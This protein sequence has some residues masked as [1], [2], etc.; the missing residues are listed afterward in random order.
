MINWRVRFKN[1]LFWVQVAASFF[2]P[3]LGYFG[4]T[5]QDFTTWPYLF[6][7]VWNAIQNPYVVMMILISL[8]NAVNDPTTEGVRDSNRAM[9]Y[10]K[11]F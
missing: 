8:W 10:K 9:T 6:K 3:I 7:V 2:V 1:P 5:A 4:L 11:P